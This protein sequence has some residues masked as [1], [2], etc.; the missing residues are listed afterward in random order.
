MRKV[1]AKRICEVAGECPWTYAKLDKKGAAERPHAM[2]PGAGCTDKPIVMLIGEAPGQMEDI[3]GVPFVGPSGDEL[4]MY[5][6]THAKISRQHCYITNLVKC[7]PGKGKTPSK[8]LIDYCA[9]YYLFIEVV[10]VEPQVIVTL[11]ALAASWLADRKTLMERVHGIPQYSPILHR[12][13]LPIYHPASGIYSPRTMHAII[14]DFRTMGD[15]V[16]GQ[17]ERPADIPHDYRIA[18]GGLVPCG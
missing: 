13:F 16:R 17:V 14:N 1:N 2:V 4:N 8:T 10:S 3:S 11:G 18:K 5:L 6:R 12:D 9:T 7:F 15:W